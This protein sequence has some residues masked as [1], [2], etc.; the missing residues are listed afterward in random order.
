MSDSTTCFPNGYTCSSIFLPLAQGQDRRGDSSNFTNT[1]GSWESCG[2]WISVL[3]TANTEVDT[4]LSSFWETEHRVSVLRVRAGYG[5]P[6]FNMEPR[7]GASPAGPLHAGML[8]IL[9]RVLVD[10]SSQSGVREQEKQLEFLG[11][12]CKRR[13]SGAG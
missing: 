6:K 8:R 5:N 11:I 12:G 13:F 10:C 4:K 2:P 7:C 1:L 9:C 3:V